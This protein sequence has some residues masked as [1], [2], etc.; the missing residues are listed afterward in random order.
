MLFSRFY[1]DPLLVIWAT[2]FVSIAVKQIADILITGS[3]FRWL[4]NAIDRNYERKGLFH[5]VLK[6][7]FTCMFCMTT[8]VS[9]WVFGLPVF[10]LANSIV[11]QTLLSLYI[12]GILSLA[13]A[14]LALG[15]HTFLEYRSSRFHAKEAEIHE[16]N[17]QVF[18][19]KAHLQ[20]AKTQASG[21][22]SAGVG[23]FE[24]AL[25]LADFSDLMSDIGNKC[26]HIGC[27]IKR[28]GCISTSIKEWYEE[29]SNRHPH[30]AA[31]FDNLE[32]D[33]ESAASR[34]VGEVEEVGGNAATSR[35]EPLYRIIADKMKRI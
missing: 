15:W 1:Q 6:Q 20:M 25:P 8:Q 32:S 4:R 5:R 35:L 23:G 22:T 2:L 16:L 28:G 19:L 11:H 30:E 21:G 3:V 9:L 34:Y 31:I 13:V 10:F 24:A 33:I 26:S 29:W 14:A 7:L 17:M 18:K 12:A 27:W